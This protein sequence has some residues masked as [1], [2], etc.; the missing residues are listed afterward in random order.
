MP[1]D[2]RF[3]DSGDARETCLVSWTLFFCT[4][5]ECA[6]QEGGDDDVSGTRGHRTLQPRRKLR[7]RYGLAS[8]LPGNASLR[9]SNRS[10]SPGKRAA[11]LPRITDSVSGP[12]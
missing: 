3:H 11:T 4:H 1:H 6:D 9:L 8:G 5:G 10:V 2:R 7:V 12:E